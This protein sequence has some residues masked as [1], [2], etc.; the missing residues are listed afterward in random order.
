MVIELAE[1]TQYRT[2]E[3]RSQKELQHLA[4]QLGLQ[5]PKTMGAAKMAHAIRVKQTRNLMDAEADAQAQR[6][7]DKGD[8]DKKPSFEEVLIFGGDFMGKTYKPSPRKAYRFINNLDPGQEFACI[9]GG[10]AFMH[11]YPMDKDKNPLLNVL[12]ECLTLKYPDLPSDAPVAD[13]NENELKKAI[14]LA[15][16]GYPVWENRPDPQFKDRMRPTIVRK[17][18]R[19]TFIEVK[20]VPQNTPFGVYFDEQEKDNETE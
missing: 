17:V 9:K 7:R 1:Q 11:L 10:A 13:K 15:E 8:P 16:I 20:K 12:P 14:S 6:M 3:E 18:P 2:L 19:F 5:L 4:E